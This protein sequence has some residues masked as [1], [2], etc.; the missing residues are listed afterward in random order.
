MSR[1]EVLSSERIYTGRI[2]TLR[3][4]T[5]RLDNGYETQ[6]EVVEHPG[7]VVIV[8]IDE[9]G[10]VFLV[11][12]YRLPVEREVLEIPAGT[13]EP[14]EDAETCAQREL[15]EEIGFRAG[16]LVRLGDVFPT[17][18]YS[19]ERFSLFLATSL[20]PSHRDAEADEQIQVVPLPLNEVLRRIEAGETQDGKTILGV[21]WAAR[22]LRRGSDS[23]PP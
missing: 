1:E 3:L 12:Q 10:R 22:R 19:T 5:V 7:S 2:V 23:T 17:P 9:Q 21:L 4:D 13:R 16:K 14:G 20:V 18:G 11:Q 8:P 6:R 15:Q